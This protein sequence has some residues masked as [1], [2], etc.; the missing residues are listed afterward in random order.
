MKKIHRSPLPKIKTI[1][2]SAGV[3]YWENS[4]NGEL[5]SERG[6]KMPFKERDN[7]C[8]VIDAETGVVKDWPKGVTANIHYKVCDH[9]SAKLKDDA[10]NIVVEY[11][12]EYVPHFMC[13]L[14][15]GFGDYIIMEID[16]EGQISD[17]EFID[18]TVTDSED[19]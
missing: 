12:E 4:V 16:G 17:W 1:E 10:G 2:V 9:F 18:S 7:W 19:E 6:D 13:P 3:R 8:P 5:D 15:N 11:D 14:E